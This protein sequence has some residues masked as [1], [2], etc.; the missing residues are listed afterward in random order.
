MVVRVA[1]RRCNVAVPDTV[2]LTHQPTD[3]GGVF[4]ENKTS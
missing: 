2:L 1:L 3:L 4:V